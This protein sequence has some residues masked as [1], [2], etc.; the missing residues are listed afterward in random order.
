MPL[1]LN[2]CL[3]SILVILAGL[4]WAGSAAAVPITFAF[5]GI[6][7]GMVDTINLDPFGASV[8]DP[9]SGQFTFES[10][11]PN[12]GSP[13]EGEYVHGPSFAFDIT[14]GTVTENGF[15]GQINVTP[16]TTSG[17]SRYSSLGFFLFSGEFVLMELV[18]E[19]SSGTAIT[20]TDLPLVPPDLAEFDPF[21]PFPDPGSRIIGLAPAAETLE[22]NIELTSLILPEPSVGLLLV[23]GVGALTFRLAA[24]RE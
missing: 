12:T 20:S 16:T 23:A 3:G 14:I 22:Y 10:T 9:V 1:R 15:L 13:G 11:T 7:R 2:R 19:D 4:S 8:G 18:L 24:F 17:S 5:T 21:A 6:V